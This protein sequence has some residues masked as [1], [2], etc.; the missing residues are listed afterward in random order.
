M[1]LVG[2]ARD[3]RTCGLMG[4]AIALR[5][6]IERR[7]AVLIV[8]DSAMA[9]KSQAKPSCS[10]AFELSPLIANTMNGA[11]PINIVRKREW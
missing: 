7:I 3:L 2:T 6:N 8:S 4:S 9:R 5:L 1:L 10:G 11:I